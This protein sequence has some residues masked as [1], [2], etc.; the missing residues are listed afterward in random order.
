M[1][2]Q[3]RILLLEDEPLLRAMLARTLTGWGYRIAT[4]GSLEDAEVLLHILGWEWPDLV[5]S[6][7]NL[8]R[9][10]H[11]LHGYLFHARW[12]ARH[13]VP[14]FL[15]M[16]GHS[17]HGFAPPP[18]GEDFRTGHILKPFAPSEL[19]PILAAMLAR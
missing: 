7:A 12:R 5:L 17:G 13:P 18:Q 6:D 15:F 3:Y 9:H 4:G 19:R 10:G 16:G 1:E 8:S 14:P 2:K 11:V